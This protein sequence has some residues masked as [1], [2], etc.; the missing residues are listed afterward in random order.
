MRLL[1]TH[2][3]LSLIVKITFSCWLFSS[4][5]LQAQTIREV[6]AGN[7]I[8]AMRIV[9]D[10]P[11]E[12]GLADRFESFM[13]N[14]EPMAFV[15]ALNSPGGNLFE[16]MKL[17]LLIRELGLWTTV[18]KE[19]EKQGSWSSL[20]DNA[21]CA[22]ACAIAFLGGKLRQLNKGARLGYHQFY[23]S[24]SSVSLIDDYLE[25]RKVY[26]DV[27]Q[28]SAILVGYLSELGDVDLDVMQIAASAP[29]EDMY[30]VSP[31]EASDLNI[32][33]GIEWSPFW[34]E[35]YKNGIVAAKRRLDSRSGYEPLY[36]YSPVA[37]V[38]ALCRAGKKVLML[39][40]S[41]AIKERPIKPEVE[42]SITDISG[43]Q[44]DLTQHDNF[45]IRNDNYRTWLD[46]SV[47]SQIE[48][49]LQ[50]AGE[51]KVVVWFPR[52]AGGAHGIS[53]SLTEQDRSMIEAAFRFCI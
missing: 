4:T 10:G 44:T 49:L 47:S 13:L 12:K 23:N 14:E 52:A 6:T 48:A 9:I 27:Q 3:T 35:P 41:G 31:A 34:L 30:W 38:T 16:G 45:L 5:M 36:F 20:D 19:G 25:E 28:I 1:L 2:I 43:K 40:T 17:G 42:W 29:P 51:L 18:Q 53:T 7:S 46:I 32:V 39:S 11:F 24:R 15:V 37:Q 50:R 22:S 33:N 26:S 21:I 8:E